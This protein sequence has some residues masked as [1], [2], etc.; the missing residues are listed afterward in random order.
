MGFS[1]QCAGTEDVHRETA[2]SDHVR[3]LLSAQ[4][5][6]RVLAHCSPLFQGRSGKPNFIGSADA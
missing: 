2:H 4:L 5:L 6:T 3:G 1:T